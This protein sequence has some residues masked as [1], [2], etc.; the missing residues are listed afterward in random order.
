M[1]DDSLGVPATWTS[2]TVRVNSIDVHYVR[3]GGDGPPVVLAHGVYEDALCRKPLLEELTDYDVI[4]YDARGHGRSSAPETGYEMDDRVTDLVG[5]LEALEID[6]ATLLGHSMGGDTVAATAAAHPDRVQALVLVDPAGMLGEEKG[7]DTERDRDDLVSA[8][9]ERIAEWHEH[10]TAELLRDD[11]ELQAHVE[12][13]QMR[14]AKR[15][16]AANLRVDP[17]IAAV[18][19]DGWLDPRETY[20]QITVPTLILKADADEGERGRHQDVA[21]LLPDGSLVHVDGAGHTVFRDEREQ[22]T[23]ELRSFLESV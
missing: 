3:T 12:A 7:D 9:R 21:S 6:T 2:G 1:S 13:G 15:I 19:E 14:L 11:P 18:F 10:T 8:V 20:P 4:A 23:A 5:V 22:A 17:A 16:A